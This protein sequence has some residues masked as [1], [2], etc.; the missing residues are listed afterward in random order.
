MCSSTR[1]PARR[2]Q[3]G[4]KAE[5]FD[6]VGGPPNPLKGVVLFQ[7]EGKQYYR[8]DL[9]TLRAEVGQEMHGQVVSDFDPKPLG[10][11]TFRVHDTKKHWEPVP[12]FGNP[13]GSLSDVL[14]SGDERYF[15][16]AG[17]F[18]GVEPYGWGGGPYYCSVARR[19]GSGG[20]LRLQDKGQNDFPGV[21]HASGGR[22]DYCLQIG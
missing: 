10:L 6:I 2:L 21:V 1:S 15:W 20:Y 14:H 13:H 12:M 18:R 5:Y 19:D 22:F 17:M 4:L 8:N 7:Y 9:E 16:K 3:P 11:V